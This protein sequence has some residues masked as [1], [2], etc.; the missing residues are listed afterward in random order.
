V[1]SDVLE[2]AE[3]V[4]VSGNDELV[5]VGALPMASVFDLLPGY[6][7]SL[8]ALHCAAGE[9]ARLMG[10]LRELISNTR[11]ATVGRDDIEETIVVQIETVSEQTRQ[12][13]RLRSKFENDWIRR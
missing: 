2:R 13:R 6:R 5:T 1:E 7:L 3:A 4:W 12:V 11:D 8:E 9:L 10:D